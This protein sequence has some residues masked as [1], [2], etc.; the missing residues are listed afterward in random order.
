MQGGIEGRGGGAEGGMGP[1]GAARLPPWGSR[2]SWSPPLPVMAS[3]VGPWRGVAELLWHKHAHGARRFRSRG[4]FLGRCMN[5]GC[6]L[7]LCA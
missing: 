4:Y 7:S 6:G 2:A 5:G 1:D 3:A